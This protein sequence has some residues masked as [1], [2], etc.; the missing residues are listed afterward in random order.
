MESDRQRI[1]PQYERDLT[2][3]SFHAIN[4]RFYDMDTRSYSPY[5]SRT[6]QG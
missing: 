2:F 5:L 4:L 6:F 3:P 1:N